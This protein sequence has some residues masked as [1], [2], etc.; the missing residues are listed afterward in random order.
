MIGKLNPYYTEGDKSY[1]LRSSRFDSKSDAIST[2]KGLKKSNR[3]NDFAVVVKEWQ[4]A[5]GQ[6]RQAIGLYV[7]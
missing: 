1:M 4:D 2:G 5:Q 7:R 3:I 6:K